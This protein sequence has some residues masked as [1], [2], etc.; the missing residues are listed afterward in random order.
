MQFSKEPRICRTLHLLWWWACREAWGANLE[1]TEKSLWGGGCLDDHILMLDHNDKYFIHAYLAMNCVLFV[2][3]ES[4]QSLREVPWVENFNNTWCI[5][6]FYVF[7]LKLES[8]FN[9][10][11]YKIFEL[12]YTLNLDRYRSDKLSCSIF[13]DSA[14]RQAQINIKLMIFLGSQLDHSSVI[15]HY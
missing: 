12:N 4:F 9:K 6:V 2:Q 13:L 7:F 8:M 5:C 11:W 1:L 15:P 3:K 14:S 10:W